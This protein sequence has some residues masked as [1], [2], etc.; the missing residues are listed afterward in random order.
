[1]QETRFTKEISNQPAALESVAKSYRSAEGKKLLRD[2][3]EILR[4]AKQVVFSGMGTSLHS[5]YLVLEKLRRVCPAVSSADAGELLHFGLDNLGDDSV[6]VATSQSGESAETRQLVER[7]QG[8]SKIISIVNDEQSFMGLNSDL[9]LPIFAGEEASI[10]NKTYTNTLA[11]LKLLAAAAEQA[12]L[13]AQC[14]SLEAAAETMRRSLTT[15]W[16]QA[17]RVTSHLG[18]LPALH[19]VARGRD[20]VTARQLSLIAKEGADIFTEALSAGL[21]RHGPIELAGPG[22]HAVF[23]LSRDSRPDLT[24]SLALETADL[25]SRVVVVTDAS[26]GMNQET[27]LEIVLETNSTSPE[28]F[29][30]LCAPFIEY[31]VHEIASANNKEAGVFRHAQKITDRE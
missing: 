18:E 24:Q 28:D 30:L 14:E 20:L 4:S 19:V 21:F 11:V 29:P 15:T 3:S 6:L 25:G 9:V 8:K 16:H 27:M 17:K 26:S 31:L 2:A 12:N 1:M 23:L 10:S 5:P 13:D 22:H 7:M